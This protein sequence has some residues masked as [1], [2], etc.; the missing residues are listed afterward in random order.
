MESEAVLTAL[1]LCAQG[2]HRWVS[3]EVVEQEL[4]RNPDEYRRTVAAELL[5]FADERLSID[6]RAAALA[7]EY[8]EQGLGTLDAL[9]L[10]VAQV[11]ECDVLLTTDDGF[12]RRASLVR[13]P[14]RV[15][16]RNPVAWILEVTR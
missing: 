8:G 11:G 9:H 7:R 3:S 14:V 6:T 16:V 13:P 15:T 12:L 2:T 4:F 5:R 10:A 1:E